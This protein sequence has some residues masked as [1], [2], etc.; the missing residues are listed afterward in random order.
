[1]QAYYGRNGECPMPIV[2]ASTPS[3]CF[4]AV[5]E[6]VR[7]SVQHMTPVMFLSDGYIANGAEP[8][9]FPSSADLPEIKT[10]F[11]SEN[12]STN[13]DEQG[14][15]QPYK[16]DD[17][18]V[19]PWAIPGTPGLEHR[20]GGLEKQD[21]TGNISYEPEN[22]QHMVKTRQAKV[23]MIANYIPE[24]KLD[25][26]PER[27]KVLVLGWG[28]TYGAIKSACAELQKQ[29]HAVSHAHLRYIRPFPKNLGAILQRFDHVLVPEINNGQLVRIIRD[30]YFI[31]AKGYN[32]IMGIPITKGELVDE[33]KTML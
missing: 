18:L 6:A 29:G 5:Y 14:K 28:S 24:Q 7:I 11:A 19:R 15:F 4:S 31:D 1:M 12:F 23:D 8:W 3:D 33:I 32:K 2:S 9:K 26:G 17:K 30:L 13:M 21:V 25:S 10:E 22:H 27:G 16:R 20:V